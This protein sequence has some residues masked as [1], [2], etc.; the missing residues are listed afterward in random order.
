MKDY[1]ATRGVEFPAKHKPDQTALPSL[2]C[3]I[4]GKGDLRSPGGNHFE[5]L[6]HIARGFL[7]LRFHD[8]NYL[9]QIGAVNV[10]IM[11]FWISSL[12]QVDPLL[13]LRACLTR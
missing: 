2:Q 6:R 5:H 13:L 4:G 8:G 11:D 1:W 7:V 3:C 9:I 10:S 12:L